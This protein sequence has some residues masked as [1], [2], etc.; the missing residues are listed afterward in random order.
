MTTLS[1]RDLRI[2]GV[3]TPCL[4]AG[5]IEASEA[6]VFVHGNPGSGEDWRLLMNQVGPFGRALAP[7]MPG[8]G[9]ADKLSAFDYTVQGY[10]RHL[11][12]LLA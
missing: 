1:V 8:F 11:G 10:A 3:R 9:R 6:V 7:H 12:A 2:N 4:E 5:P